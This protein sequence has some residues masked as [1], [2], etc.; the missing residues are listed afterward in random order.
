MKII[1]VWSKEVLYVY[2]VVF[3]IIVWIDWVKKKIFINFIVVLNKFFFVIFK[4]IISND[5]DGL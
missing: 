2:V 3:F 4:V 5:E 1:Y